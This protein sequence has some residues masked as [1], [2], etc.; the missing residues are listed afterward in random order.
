MDV[1]RLFRK[2]SLERLNSPEEL[3][4][5]VKQVP[6][7]GWVVVWMFAII[8]ISVIVWGFL[9]SIATKV[10]ASGIIM[11]SGGVESVYSD[12]PGVVKKVLVKNSDMVQKGDVIAL[13]A[14]PELEAEIVLK[15]EQLSAS[16]NQYFSSKQDIQRDMELSAKIKNDDQIRIND[17]IKYM[18]QELQE[19]TAQ[20]HKK[21][22]LYKEGLV[23][24]YDVD[25]AQ[26]NIN[27][28]KLKI[29]TAQNELVS[30]DLSVLEKNQNSQSNLRSNKDQIDNFVLSLN[31]L[32]EKYKKSSEIK[33]QLSGKVIEVDI[34]AGDVIAPG[35]SIIEI[36]KTGEEGSLQVVFFTS[37]LKGKSIQEGFAANIDP[38]IVKKE[39][40]GFMR[41]K[42]NYVSLFPASRK[43]V[44]NILNNDAL[45][46]SF[47]QDGPPIVVYASLI[48]DKSTYSGF[49]WSSVKGPNIHITSG[50]MCDVEVTVREQAPI[51]LVIPYIKKSLGIE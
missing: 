34:S 37:A 24:K 43:S 29:K 41:A 48:K 15:E 11:N 16:Q 39:E 13:I 7:K 33:A 22:E 9:G 21:Q 45:S 31:V 44:E 38:T 46:S 5:L 32:K 28:V 10:K 25:I 18:K 1:N 40:Y 49:K 19:L 47:M 51:T 3:D 12:F 35:S 23:R 36:E 2:K 4:M 17:N 14:Q 8:I 30:N 50:T 26:N 27:S 6:T 20:L 42:V